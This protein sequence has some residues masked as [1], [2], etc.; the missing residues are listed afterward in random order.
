MLL[1]SSF[2]IFDKLWTPAEITT[3]LWLDPSDS[4]TVTTSGSGISEWRDKSGNN[5]HIIESLVDRR[6]TY[7]GTI[8]GLNTI[9]F[10]G[11]QNFRPGALFAPALTLNLDIVVVIFKLSLSGGE[12]QRVISLTTNASADYLNG[13]YLIPPW[14]NNG[15]S[16]GG[17]GAFWASKGGTRGVEEISIGSE[18]RNWNSFTY[19]GLLGEIVFIQEA[20]VDTKS[21]VE[22]YLAHKWGLIANLPID[23]PYKNTPPYV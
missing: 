5:R 14:G 18:A 9:S 4:S 2:D 17:P 20:S 6:P 22:G 8:N 16:P 15:R 21:L 13:Y 3:A 12:N 10:N 19:V 7:S 11:L 23:H 1:Y